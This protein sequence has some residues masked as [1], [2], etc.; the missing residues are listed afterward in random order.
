MSMPTAD[1]ETPSP[2]AIS[3]S[4]PITTNSVVPMP[5]AP[6]ARASRARGTGVELQGTRGVEPADCV[7]LGCRAEAGAPHSLQVQREEPGSH[8]RIAGGAAHTGGGTVPA[9]GAPGQGWSRTLT[10]PSFFS[11]KLA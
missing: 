5:K 3:G 4:M 6:M 9:P 10:A 1:T 8:A 11:R 7:V 2:A